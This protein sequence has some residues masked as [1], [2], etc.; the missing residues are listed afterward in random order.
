MHVASAQ[1][2]DKVAEALIKGGADLKLVSL[3]KWTALHQAA[4]TGQDKIIN[5]LLKAGAEVDAR[6][7]DE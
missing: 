5:L 6:E 2:H 1:G 3:A 7:E 4:E